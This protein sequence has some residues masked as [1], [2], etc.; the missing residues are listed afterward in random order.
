MKESEK[1]DNAPFFYNTP[2]ICKSNKYTQSSNI[3]IYKQKV[4]ATVHV[5]KRSKWK[6]PH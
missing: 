3:N 1:L 4:T 2:F 6:E 5:T